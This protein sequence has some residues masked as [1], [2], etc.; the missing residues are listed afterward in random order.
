MDI[1]RDFR[2]IAV[3]V[4]LAGAGC[5]GWAQDS[6]NS[7]IDDSNPKTSAFVATDS[8]GNQPAS[9]EELL[10][11]AASD[12]TTGVQTITTS[13]TDAAGH[14]EETTF[15]VIIVEPSAVDLAAAESASDSIYL[16]ER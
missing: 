2:K 12:F 11:I 13:K 6:N 8:A 9:A 1:L 10:L 7:T 4:F 3:C 5:N 16:A 15:N 14:L